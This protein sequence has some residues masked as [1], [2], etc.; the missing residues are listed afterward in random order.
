MRETLCRLGRWRG[1]GV[2]SICARSG[3]SLSMDRLFSFIGPLAS[4]G[5][6]HWTHPV[7]QYDAHLPWDGILSNRATRNKYRPSRQ[8]SS[9]SV[10]LE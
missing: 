3:R 4:T 2:S 6:P 5:N 9:T 7:E 1:Y 8:A 10:W